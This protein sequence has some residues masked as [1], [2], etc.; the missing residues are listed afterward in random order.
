MYVTFNDRVDKDTQTK[1]NK[2]N[3]KKKNGRRHIK[4]GLNFCI[5]CERNQTIKKK[6]LIEAQERKVK[7]D[8]PEA[9][10]SAVSNR[11][12]PFS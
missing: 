9:Y 7:S 10:T 1:E 12:T 6:S 11:F 5:C 3:V 8:L 2:I 4:T